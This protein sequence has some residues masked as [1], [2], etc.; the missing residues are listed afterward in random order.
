[1]RS[2]MLAFMKIMFYCIAIVLVC[3]WRVMGG[4]SSLLHSTRTERPWAA[5]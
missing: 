5:W 2:V 4:L 3:V 1:M